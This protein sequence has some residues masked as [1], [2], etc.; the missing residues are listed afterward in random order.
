M[1]WE[2]KGGAF[3]RFGLAH[4]C[5][6]VEDGQ[7]RGVM[8]SAKWPEKGTAGD[9]HVTLSGCTVKISSSPP[10]AAGRA[11]PRLL[12]PASSGHFLDCTL[13]NNT[14]TYHVEQ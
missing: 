2:K 14:Y 9:G 6:G 10:A 8:R 3:S 1:F 5:R 12:R 13:D 4:E 7:A 11:A